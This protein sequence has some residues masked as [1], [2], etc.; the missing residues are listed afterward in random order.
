MYKKLTLSYEKISSRNEQTMQVMPVK[1]L[2]TMRKMYAVLG[3]L[4]K[5]EAGYITGV[6]DHLEGDVTLLNKVLILYTQ[7]SR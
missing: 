4:K 5:N 6:I 2:M 1:R 3:S 7:T